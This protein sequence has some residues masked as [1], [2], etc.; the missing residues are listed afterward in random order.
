MENLQMRIERQ[1]KVNEHRKKAI[2]RLNKGR[3]SEETHRE[4][5]SGKEKVTEFEHEGRVTRNKRRQKEMEQK[6]GRRNRTRD[7]RRRGQE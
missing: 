4:T 1:K 5:S 7:W 2:K 3:A 6:P